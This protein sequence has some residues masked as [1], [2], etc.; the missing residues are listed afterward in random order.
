VLKKST[1]SAFMAMILAVS[2][3]AAC[4]GDKNSAGQTK[5]EKTEQKASSANDE[6]KK[7]ASQMQAINKQ[8]LDALEAKDT[9]KIKALG[10]SINDKWLSFENAVRD[11]FPLLYTKVEK[12]E[13]PIFAESTMAHPDL[14]GMR[15]NARNLQQALDELKTAKATAQK[16]SELLD[17]AVKNYKDYVLEQADHLVEA[18]AK[19]TAA[20]KAGDIEKAKQLYPDA[21]V[22]YE[23][24]EPIAESFGDLDP[25]IDARIDD[26]D[27]PAKWTG[28]HRLEKAL[29][30]DHSLKGQAKYADQLLSDVKDLKAKIQTLKLKPEAMVA[31]AMELLNEAAI[32]KVTGEEERYSHIDLVDLSANVEGSQAVYQAVIPALNEHN[33]ALLQELDTR[34]RKMEEKMLTYKSNGRYIDYTKLSKDQVR[35]LS[36]A[37]SELSKSMSQTAE[38][39]D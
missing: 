26:V 16:A 11:R 13:Q 22:Y 7:G 8:L 18:T 38:I 24:I 10:K 32:S 21:R 25:K 31:G 4:N 37:L 29:W 34:F 1:L 6:I 33:K 23:R 9:A 5:Q 20:V 14:T 39:L 30:K 36:Q 17:K 3:L 28:F 12:Y 19:F 27:D 2:M 15:E 35:E